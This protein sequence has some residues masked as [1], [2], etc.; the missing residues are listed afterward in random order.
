M[1]QTSEI[2]EEQKEELFAFVGEN[3][4]YYEAAWFGANGTKFNWVAFFFPLPW[5]IY[6]KMY[7][8]A[9]L[10]FL[11]LLI[12]VVLSIFLPEIVIGV[13]AGAICGFLGNRWYFK[14]VQRKVALV[15][16]KE[17]D[18]EKRLE[19]L[20]KRGGVNLGGA[21]AVGFIGLV[22]AILQLFI[23]VQSTN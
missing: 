16:W 1:T 22:L 7:G 21:I 12:G 13:L 11:A 15:Q 23:P 18:K 6:R 5:F 19:I 4:G 9:G 10:F 2:T 3:E 17:P 8:V 14:H 20:K